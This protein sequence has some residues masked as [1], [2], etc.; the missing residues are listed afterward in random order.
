MGANVRHPLWLPASTEPGMGVFS[1]LYAVESIARA[2]LAT[3]IPLQAYD[4]LKD[5]ETRA[6]FDRGEIDAAG[7][8]EI[9]RR[10]P[11]A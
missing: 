1:F 6:R 10:A 7:A 8:A 3:V 2:S 9:A 11:A 5:P 4:L